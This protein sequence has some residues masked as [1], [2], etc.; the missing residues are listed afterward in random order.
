MGARG[1]ALHAQGAPL[2][3]SWKSPP[4]DLSAQLLVKLLSKKLAW[5]HCWMHTPPP[6]CASLPSSTLDMT[7]TFV[8]A[9]RFSAPPGARRRMQSEQRAHTAALVIRIFFRGRWACALRRRPSAYP[10]GDR[11]AL[12]QHSSAAQQRGAR[13]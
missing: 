2:H 12:A 5:P 4:P 1:C 9:F 7:V 10:L 11:V 3:L 8:A 6:F 13:A